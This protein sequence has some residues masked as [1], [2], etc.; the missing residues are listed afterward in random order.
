MAHLTPDPGK[1]RVVDQWTYHARLYRASA[2][3]AQSDNVSLV[4]LVSFGCGLDAVTADQVEEILAAS[5]RLYTQIKIDEGANLGAARIRVRS[6]LATMRERR[7]HAER[8]STLSLPTMEAVRAVW[9][10]LRQVTNGGTE[11]A[12]LSWR[13]LSFHTGIG[14]CRARLICDMFAQTGLLRCETPTDEGFRC[15]LTAAPGTKIDLTAAP[16]YQKLLRIFKP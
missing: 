2:Y 14:M 13:R 5:G 8:K 6:L 12:A 11:S 1:L 15:T 3:A 16:L 10:Y 9:L 7:L 4:Q